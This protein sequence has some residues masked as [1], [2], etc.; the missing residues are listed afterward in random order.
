MEENQAMTRAG[1]IALLLC[2]CGGKSAP[3]PPG[4]P[5]LT[6]ASAVSPL[7]SSACGA[8]GS[9]PGSAVEP[10]VAIDPR[11]SRHLIGVWQQDRFGDGGARGLATSV[12]FDGG[13]TWTSTAARFSLC[14]GGAYERA[15]DP[16]VTIG[17]DG[18]AWQIALAFNRSKA[19]QAILT[20]R[21]TDGGRTWQDPIALQQRT[22]P[23]FGMD[24]ET[25]T[26]DP[27]DP[28]YVYAVW[29]ELTGQT[30]PSSPSD[31]G[32]TWFSRSTDGGATWEPARIIYDPGA[33][34][35]TIGNQIA[36]TPDGTLVNVFSLVTQNSSQT[37][38]STIAVLRSTDRGANWSTAPGLVAEALFVGVFDPK[39]Q[40]AVRSGD[41][42]PSIAAGS[43]GDT[44]YALWEDARFSNGARDGIAVSHSLDAGL[45]WTAPVQVNL[46][47]GAQ[48]FTRAATVSPTGKLGVTYYDLRNDDLND[49]AHLLA[50]A[51]LAIS[52]DN[53]STF[54]EQALAPAFDLRTAP[55]AQGYFLGDYQGLVRAGESFLPFFS[56]T[57]ANDS[58]H[59]QIFFRPA[60][61][62]AAAAAPS[63][64]QQDARRPIR[65]VA[66]TAY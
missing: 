15:S 58:G 33:D 62:G 26:A 10:M 34:A 13:A 25:I 8:S 47:H 4:F 2:G 16:W 60:A 5:G 63:F 41:V 50:T 23:D 17:P 61:P 56:M 55:F 21:S 30:D 57:N 12:T 14:T 31:R 59:A 6:I 28:H 42:I 22:D 43:A 44:V 52:A 64:V 46:A 18:T 37:P 66:R 9:Y 27:H 36:V 3:R 7:N 1:L 53:G 11:D 38:K 35:Q 39:S 45:H 49:G 32:P 51:F 20:S 65:T 40:K 54:V 24:K 19:G 29:D 48:A